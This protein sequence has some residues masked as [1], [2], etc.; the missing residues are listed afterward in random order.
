MLG[1]IGFVKV[2][3]PLPYILVVVEGLLAC[4]VDDVRG[5]GLA[6]YDVEGHAAV[7]VFVEVDGVMRV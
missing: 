7:L 4:F 2:V 6:L 5:S 3:S 1:G